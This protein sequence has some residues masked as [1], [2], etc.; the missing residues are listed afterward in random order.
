MDK[1]KQNIRKRFR[2]DVT[3]INEITREA[4]KAHL[5]LV[6]HA[7]EFDA[8]VLKAKEIAEHDSAALKEDAD[9]LRDQMTESFIALGNL[10]DS[11]ETTVSK[12][13]AIYSHALEGQELSQDALTIVK[14]MKKELTKYRYDAAN[15]ATLINGF[16]EL[17]IVEQ[18]IA[19]NK[20]Y[21]T[22]LLDMIGEAQI[23]DYLKSR[24]I[25]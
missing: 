7:N 10:R 2:Q 11:V 22:K 9:T 21:T 14:T 6:N 18:E 8:L 24:N 23:K 13:Q 12:I 15:T 17:D 19:S 25:E 3:I 4:E 5:S 1:F 16:L 20:N